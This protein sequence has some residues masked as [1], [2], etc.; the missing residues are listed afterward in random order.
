MT[1]L[2]SSNS[3]FFLNPA[4]NPSHTAGILLN[5]RSQSSPSHPREP[6]QP[7]SFTSSSSSASQTSHSQSPSS[8][9][10][11]GACRKIRFAPLPAPRRDEL[12]TVFYESDSDCQSPH[13][14]GGHTTFHSDSQP[15][16]SPRASSISTLQ[17]DDTASKSKSKTWGKKLL[18]PLLHPLLPSTTSNGEESYSALFRTSSRDSPKVNAD[19]SSDSYKYGVPLVRRMS[20]GSRAISSTKEAERSRIYHD[21]APLMPVMSEGFA[22]KGRKD[23]Q[24]M[25]NGR[26]YGRRVSASQHG[27]QAFY[28]PE[29]VEWGYGGMGSVVNNQV[30][31]RSG[32][33]WARL[34]SKG[35][36]PGGGADVDE[37][38]DGSGM[39]WVRRRRAQRERE[40]R[41]REGREKTNPDHAVPH[42]AVH[43]PQSK[44]ANDFPRPS[45]GSDD[46]D[47]PMDSDEDHVYRAVSIPAPYHHVRH[48]SHHR[49]GDGSGSATPTSA[50]PL[51]R[52]GSS[53]SVP[54]FRTASSGSHGEILPTMSERREDA[55]I[56][57][58]SSET[59]STSIDE[60]DEDD[61]ENDTERESDDDDQYDVGCAS[62]V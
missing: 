42:I 27:K 4:N 43:A 58:E 23:G 48:L 45:P 14:R 5:S 9:E 19:L 18:R 16:P 60:D 55:E 46:S 32:P 53:S 62:Y 56:S 40:E 39:G 51:S 22:S 15:P 17:P 59:S 6:R 24:R 57:S 26:V 31:S 21:G 44:E 49:T 2:V 1:A 13:S 54:L 35:K 50:P 37:E 25:L 29:F 3:N 8:T 47:Q 11:E 7:S 12:P 52:A 61:E 34:Q 41:E 10:S 30:R 36:V 33:D 38:D 28:E 20:T